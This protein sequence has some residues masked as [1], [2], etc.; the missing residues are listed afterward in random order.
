MK[1]DN[2]RSPYDAVGGMVYFGRMLDK[3]R[4]HAQGK[5][6]AD[7]IENLGTGFDG[8]CCGF[9]RMPYDEIKSKVLADPTL[10]DVQMLEWC[11]QTGRRLNQNDLEIWN[12]FM[13]KRGW[14]DEAHER[15]LFRLKEA[16]LPYDGKI[17]TMFDYIDYD[18]GRKSQRHQPDCA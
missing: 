7:M 16:G 3:I 2:L 8:R 1:I 12:E 10:N 13:I 14:R 4:L 9:L 6:P 15:L 18:E 5:L 17:M 11:F